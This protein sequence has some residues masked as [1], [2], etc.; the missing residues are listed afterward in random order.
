MAWMFLDLT[1]SHDAELEVPLRFERLRLYR[2]GSLVFGRQTP[3]R[4]LRKAEP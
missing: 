4:A 3:G 2:R 1:V